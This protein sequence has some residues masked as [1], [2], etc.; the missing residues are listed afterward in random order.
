MKQRATK[1]LSDE[2][3]KG[4]DCRLPIADCRLRTV[5]WAL[6]TSLLG[7]LLLV[8]TLVGSARAEDWP[9]WRGPGRDG[10][11][12][13]TGWLKGWEQGK[14]PQVLWRAQVGKGHAALSVSNGRA[15]TMGWNGHED[16]VWCLDAA[17]GKVIWKQSYPCKG[18]LQWPGP[19]STPTV[20]GATVHTL[21]Q[22]GQ[23][24]AWDAASGRPVWKVQLPS[25]YN[26]DEDYGFAWSPLVEGDL[27]ILG[28]GSKGLAVRKKDGTFAWGHDGKFGACVSPAPHVSEG[29]RAVAVVTVNP[30]RNSSMVVGVEAQS[31]KELWRYGPWNE[32]WGAVCA[33]LVTDGRSFMITSAEEHRYAARFT[34][35]KSGAKED[36]RTRDFASYTGSCVLID[37]HVYGVHYQGALKCIDWKTGQVKWQHRDFGRHGT[38]MAAD[39]KL[40]VQNSKGGEL[41]IVEATPK[42]YTELRRFEVFSGGADTFT[43]PVLANGKVY[44]R[45]YAGEVACVEA[46]GK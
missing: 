12:G 33:D 41:V 22:H 40:L 30:D 10:I 31:G 46:G 5:G 34:V 3:T 39:G 6:P 42:Q 25:Q 24:H 35:G 29:R 27:L 15:Y 23:L 28:T 21:G 19:R 43:V 9:Q 45:S 1:R 2:A 37:G 32:K 17:T 14:A 44:C 20:D 26:P 11:S 16:T 36:W 18:I 38:L 13:E 7:T 4:R 8:V